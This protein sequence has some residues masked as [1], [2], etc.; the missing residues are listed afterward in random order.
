MD[1]HYG[2]SSKRGTKDYLNSIPQM[3]T[4]DQ[5]NRKTKMQKI[6]VVGKF[7][8]KGTPQST[9]TTYGPTYTVTG[10]LADD[11]AEIKC[12]L[13]GD[14]ANTIKNGD[15]LKLLNAYSRNGRLFNKKD[16]TEEIRGST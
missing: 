15:I 10:F 14:I 3:H 12:Q 1:I 5:I 6:N 7:D 8:R 9:S 11:T 13:W 16:G 4:I 2:L